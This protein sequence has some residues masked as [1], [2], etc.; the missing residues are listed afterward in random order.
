LKSSSRAATKVKHMKAHFDSRASTVP[1]MKKSDLI[2]PQTSLLASVSRIKGPSPGSNHIKH[3]SRSG[4][5]KKPTFGEIYGITGEQSLTSKQ[6]MTHEWKLP[7]LQ[8][9]EIKRF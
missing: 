5:T 3:E 9:S 8:T 7:K 1:P 2:A 4:S 6:E